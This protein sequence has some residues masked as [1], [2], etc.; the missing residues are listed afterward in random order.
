MSTLVFALLVVMGLASGAE[1]GRRGGRSHTA[2]SGTGSKS[3]SHSVRGYTKR[4]GTYVAPHR[5]TNA[6]RTQRNN[7]ST[8]GN[9]NTYTGKAG[10]RSATR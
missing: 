7:Y 9:V 2:P 8:K 6:D 4:S 3:S 5:R 1:A 10:T